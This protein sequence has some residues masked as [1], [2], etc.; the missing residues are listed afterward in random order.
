MKDIDKKERDANRFYLIYFASLLLVIYIVFGYIGI[1]RIVDV[2]FGRHDGKNVP[3]KILTL[4]LKYAIYLAAKTGLEK[5]YDNKY[6]A[7]MEGYKHMLRFELIIS[8]DGI[9]VP[10]FK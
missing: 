8:E 6:R 3:M 9:N 1:D 4:K 7:T 10:I 2:I 5:F